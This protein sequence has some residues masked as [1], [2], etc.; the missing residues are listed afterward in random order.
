MRFS[1]AVATGSGKVGNMG[2]PSMRKFTML[3]NCVSWVYALE[4]YNRHCAKCGV[5]CDVNVANEAVAFF[6]RKLDV[7]LFP[8]LKA[9]AIVVSELSKK[10]VC[11][12]EWMYQLEGQA[13]PHANWNAFAS[14]VFSGDFVTASGRRDAAVKDRTL[15]GRFVNDWSYEKL[16]RA[17]DEQTFTPTTITFH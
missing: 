2:T 9:T 8:K 3:G 4:R 14:S 11:D 10:D 16:S 13:D 12:E 15:Q 6:A 7:V 5:L 1:I 17:V